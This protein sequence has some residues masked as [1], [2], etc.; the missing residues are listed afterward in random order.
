MKTMKNKWKSD[1]LNNTSQESVFKNN[2]KEEWAKQLIY[3]NKVLVFQ[4][5]E[6][7]KRLEELIIANKEL[8]FHNAEIERSAAGV[9]VANKE[10]VFQNGE[11]EKLA[12]ELIY[13][14][15]EQKET[16]S[17]IR[18]LNER[19]EQKLAARASELESINKELE[20]FAY[21][22]SHD[23]K[24]PLRAVHGYAQILRESYGVQSEPETDRLLGN[25]L[26]NAIR[27][28]LLIE[29]LLTLSR[30]GRKELVKM[31]IAMF[32]IVTDLCREIKNENNNRNIQFK[33]NDLEP[34]HGDLVS[35]KQVWINL[36]S[37][38][39]KYSKLKENT[40]I[41]IGSGKKDN[42]ITY[43]VK[44]NGAGFDMR[45]ANKLFGIFQRLHNDENFEGTGGG[46]A[47]VHRIISRH[48][49]RVWAEGGVNQGAMFSFALPKNLS[50]G[51]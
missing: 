12:A 46:L 50:N 41:E 32:D 16:E 29:D 4:N 31:D 40:V 15:K 44:D 20:S 13:I 6:K 51:T 35:I 30:F 7:E 3:T 19:L 33:I 23:L 48:G 42:E 8:A 45:Y 17:D 10:L 22:V 5:K 28:G 49:G 34:A 14:N 18:R 39:V 38:A 2:E 36:I 43:Y 26:K 27:M 21:S 47:I 24:A 37:N 11:K 9:V 1:E 25:I